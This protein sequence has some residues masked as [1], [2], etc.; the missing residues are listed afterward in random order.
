MQGSRPLVWIL[1]AALVAGCSPRGKERTDVA[2]AQTA[3]AQPQL[4]VSR[5]VSVEAGLEGLPSTALALDLFPRNAAGSTFLVASDVDLPLD[6]LAEFA[7]QAY[8]RL[9]ERLGV[10]PHWHP[11]PPILVYLASGV[12]KLLAVEQRL[13]LPPSAVP[14]RSFAFRGGF[15]LQGPVIAVMVADLDGTRRLLA[16]EIAHLGLSRIVTQPP[17]LVNEGL[18]ELFGGWMHLGEE[19]DWS[20]STSVHWNHERRCRRAVREG[21]IPTLREI[22]ALDYWTFRADQNNFLYFALGWHFV[23]F[24]LEDAHPQVAGRFDLYLDELRSGRTGFEAFRRAYDAPLVESLWRQELARPIAW[25]PLFNSWSD[26]NDG[27]RSAVRA[28]GS[29]AL[30]HAERPRPDTRFELSFEIDVPVTRLPPDAGVGFVLAHKGPTDFHLLSLLDCGREVALYHHG[31]APTQRQYLKRPASD[32]TSTQLALVIETD[33]S[34]LLRVDGDDATRF[35]P[36]KGVH[37]GRLGL[38]LEWHSTD[39]DSGIEMRFRRVRLAG[40]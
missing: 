13:G 6:E 22:F 8:L 3:Q 33:G 36:I 10:P 19:L 37:D 18:A 14:G 15:Y 25:S 34:I 35:G 24:L 1:G 5:E 26:T 7:D 9:S 17:D 27:F 38:M 30:L 23:R 11:E 39:P 29:A 20:D 16:H 12:D 32:R 2:V 40:G 4:T 28:R 21:T 31:G